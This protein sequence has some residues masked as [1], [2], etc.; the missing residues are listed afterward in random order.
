MFCSKNILTKRIAINSLFV[1]VTKW[2]SWLVPFHFRGAVFVHVG[3]EHLC[4]EN[5]DSFYMCSTVEVAWLSQDI[6][7]SSTRQRCAW[8]G[9]W[10]FWIQNPAAFNKIRSEVIFPVAGS[11]LDLDFVF[12][13]K[14]LLVLCLTY[15]FPDSNRSRIA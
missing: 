7:H 10:I 6:R 9:F 11:G 1:S 15:I 8:T 12:T 3:S 5:G 14:T 2:N 13:E 4:T